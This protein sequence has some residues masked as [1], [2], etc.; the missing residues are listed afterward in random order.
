MKIY[1]GNLS[2]DVTEGE[3]QQE[4]KAY[5]EVTSVSILT[6]KFVVNPRTGS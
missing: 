2:Y 1:V 5:G 3:L 4:F 6:D